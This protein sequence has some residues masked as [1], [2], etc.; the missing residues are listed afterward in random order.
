MK[1]AIS[2][3]CWA[4]VLG[5]IAGAAQAQAPGQIVL[6]L[7]ADAS[8]GVSVTPTFEW[9]SDALADSYTIEVADDAGFSNIVFLESGITDTTKTL[10]IPLA[11]ATV[12][13]W[14]V[15][16]TNGDGPGPDSDTWSFTTIVLPPDEPNLTSPADDATGVS[17]S[18]T[19]EWSAVSGADTYTVELDDDPAFGSIDRDQ[20]SA[21]TSFSPAVL[22]AG[23]EYHWRVKASNDG[24]DSGYS[25]R[26]FTTAYDAP[27][28]PSLTAPSDAATNVALQP[29]LDWDV[30][31]GTVSSYHIQVST[32]GF[33]TFAVRD[34]TIAE[35]TT[36]FA[37]SSPLATS[38]LYSW[39]V[40]A[41]N[42]DGVT[43]SWSSVRT[44]ATV[45]PAP[46]APTLTSPADDVAGVSTTPTLQWDAVSGADTY[47]V[48]LDT[49]PAFNSIDQSQTSA[50][51]SFS[52]E[53]LA[54]GT[55]YHWRVRATNAGGVSGYSSRS[56]TTSFAPPGAPTLSSPADGAND[57][58]LTPT[59]TWAA[60][61][62]TNSFYRID[63]S[64]DNDFTPL[65][66]SDTTVT[67]S[68]IPSAPLDADQQYFWRVRGDNNGGPG[69]FSATFDFT[70]VP[71]APGQ[72][73]LTSP[74]DDAVEVSLTPNLNWASESGADSYRLQV[75][76]VANFASTV[77]DQSGIGSSNYLV[78]APLTFG[79][80]YF[81]RVRA[82]NAGGEGLYSAV[83]SF[84]TITSKVVVL[85]SPS[86]GAVGIDLSP[87]LSWNAVAGATSYDVQVSKSSDMSSPIVNQTG[88]AA[89]SLAIGP[90]DPSAIHHWRVRADNAASDQWS[91]TWSFVTGTGAPGIVTLVSPADDAT[92]VAMLPTFTWNA[93]NGATDYQ[94]DL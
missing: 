10:A 92:G 94:F 9:F 87:T 77:I 59:L 53:A 62:G 38:T 47:T 40:R 37:P 4:L 49:D 22:A 63:I 13:H 26:S 85:T 6:E 93:V 3:P 67:L 91:L 69:N 27:G 16:G 70:T 90:L 56:F 35:G 33:S 75:S 66:I 68:Y 8:T 19:L 2:G 57:V 20:T 45:P 12:Y 48:D 42:P 15:R 74:T 44:F 65:V 25:S 79:T 64:T 34:S 61:T 76:T 50:S 54:A 24:G 51:T 78:P 55:Q 73:T 21:S 11:N 1:R 28:A 86:N 32:D 18:P 43:G 72:V 82:E 14:R 83:W 46:V 17:T 88:V 84:T 58:P 30:A 41:K 52:P 29:T 60:G 71:P 39:R 7:P 31:S 5:L 23:T 89:T 81:W 80:E 36:D